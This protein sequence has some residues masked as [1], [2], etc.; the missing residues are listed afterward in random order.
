MKGYRA[1][2]RRDVIKPNSSLNDSDKMGQS[3]TFDT[4]KGQEGK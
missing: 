2:F 4:H 1:K 3:F